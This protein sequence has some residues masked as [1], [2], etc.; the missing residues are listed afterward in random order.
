MHVPDAGQAA[1]QNQVLHDR[2][3]MQVG[4]CSE[5]NKDS[6]QLMESIT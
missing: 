1:G 2:V 5:V 4:V 6:T 3:E